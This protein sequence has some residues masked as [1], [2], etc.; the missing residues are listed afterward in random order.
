LR[1]K[2]TIHI[3][4][5]VII[6]E[7]HDTDRHP[8]TFRPANFL[9]A[10][11]LFFFLLATACEEF[12]PMSAETFSGIVAL[13][14][15]QLAEID[16]VILPYTSRYKY[17]SAGIVLDEEIVLTRSYREDRIGKQDEYASVS[18]PVASMIT[19]QMLE[20]GLIGSL[21]DPIGDYH[22]KY[23]DVLPDEYPD[24]PITFAHL[25]SHRSGIPH[26]DDIWKGGKLALEFAPGESIMYSTRGYGVLGEVL[27]EIAG[28]SYNRLV[29]EYIGDKVGAGS[30]ECPSPFFEAPGGSVKSS[31]GD[32]AL[33]ARGV[34]N[35]IYV[36]DSLMLNLAWVPIAIDPTGMMAM[37]WY[38]E[39]PDTG[40]L[41][42]YHAGSNGK[43]RAFIL[44]MPHHRSAVVLMG[45]NES[46]DGKQLFPSMATE[47]MQVLD[48]FTSE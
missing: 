16:A 18:K 1:C 38:V 25:L 12:D 10:V 22:E 8:G 47:V 43:R 46:S 3:F 48:H 21:D 32:M 9:L 29:R 13:N 27:S 15:G 33:F 28:K 5:N 36:Q 42:V 24:V 17:I 35:G 2:Y 20:E 7:H 41:T 11:F 34:I 6:T 26:H 23:R 45:K 30:I 4:M 14:E 39:H 37:G 40:E 44:I 31:V 19:M